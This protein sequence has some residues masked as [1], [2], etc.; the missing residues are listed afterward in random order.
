[1]L[2]GSM[3]GAVE[4]RVVS[5]YGH[6][7]LGGIDFPARVVQLDALT[8]KATIIGSR[9]AQE[10]NIIGVDVIVSKDRAELVDEPDEL[11]SLTSSV[12]TRPLKPPSIGGKHRRRVSAIPNEGLLPIN[13]NSLFPGISEDQVDILDY[14]LKKFMQR[15]GKVD[16]TWKLEYDDNKYACKVYSQTVGD[17][18]KRYQLICQANIK[19]EKFR[20]A[21]KEEHTQLKFQEE[22][23]IQPEVLRAWGDNMKVVRKLK[24]GGPF[25]DMFFSPREVIYYLWNVEMN[26]CVYRLMTSLEDE[27]ETG[28]GKIDSES[29][30]IRAF[31]QAGCGISYHKIDADRTQIVLIHQSDLGGWLP[32]YFVSKMIC[33]AM[34]TKVT[35]FLAELGIKGGQWKGPSALRTVMTRKGLTNTVALKPNQMV[36]PTKMG[37]MQS[38]PLSIRH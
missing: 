31:C 17:G 36:L 14:S 28:L 2:S 34:K 4:G 30:Y 26:G 15:A 24:S 7:V 21:M 38:N 33:T 16:V 32:E 11:Q 25:T 13:P 12:T 9:I 5:F 27:D 18:T 8:V 22:D 19:F 6:V 29:R 37:C 10:H 20:E 3:I 1:M 35:K 23:L